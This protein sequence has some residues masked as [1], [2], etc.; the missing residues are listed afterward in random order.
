[1]HRTYEGDGRVVMGIGV[2]GV[3]RWKTTIIFLFDDPLTKMDTLSMYPKTETGLCLD[4]QE[5]IC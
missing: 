1:M 2:M 5:I 3:I 4:E